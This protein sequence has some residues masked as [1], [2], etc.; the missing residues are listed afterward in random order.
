[1]SGNIVIDGIKFRATVVL[2]GYARSRYPINTQ[3]QQPQQA[4]DNIVLK[5]FRYPS[6]GS[7]GSFEMS[8]SIPTDFKRF[9]D[10][11][12]Y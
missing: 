7:H 11:R 6:V 8:I 3:Y 12:Y 5:Y 9:F 1:M 4:G 2:Q 10:K